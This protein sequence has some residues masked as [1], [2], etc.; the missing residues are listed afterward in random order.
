[1]KIFWIYNNKEE[2]RDLYRSPGIVAAV[3][4]RRLYGLDMWLGCGESVNSYR[5]LVRKRLLRSPTRIRRITLRW[6][7]GRRIVRMGDTCK[8]FR[9]VFNDV[10]LI[11]VVEL[12]VSARIV[13][14]KVTMNMEGAAAHSDS[15]HLN[16][17]ASDTWAIEFAMNSA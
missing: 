7:L 3:K 1:M 11:S 5:I 8:W 10:L 14:V 9:I 12:S 6:I 4:R 15:A 13:L 16:G 17:Y 2:I